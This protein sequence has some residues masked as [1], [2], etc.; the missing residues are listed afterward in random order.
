MEHSV[1]LEWNSVDS[2]LH[3]PALPRDGI[4]KICIYDFDNTLFKS[5]APNPHLYSAELYSSLLSPHVFSNGGWWSE[6]RF[7]EILV[8]EWIKGSVDDSAF[9]NKDIVDSARRSWDDRDNGTLTIL[10]TGRKELLFSPLFEKLLK[11]PVFGRELLFHSAFLKRAGYPTTMKYKIA[12]LRSVMDFYKEVNEIVIY[13][14]RKQQLEGFELFFEDYKRETSR[15]FNH[16]LIAVK[17]VINYLPPGKEIGTVAKIF[18]EHNKDVRSKLEGLEMV[19]GPICSLGFQMDNLTLDEDSNTVRYLLDCRETHKIRQL[20]TQ[21]S[22]DTNQAYP[23]SLPIIVP[24][25]SL[26]GSQV[27]MFQNHNSVTPEASTEDFRKLIGDATCFCPNKV[28]DWSIRE[29]ISLESS[30][31]AFSVGSTQQPGTHIL[32]TSDYSDE[33]MQSVMDHINNRGSLAEINHSLPSFSA[34]AIPKYHYL[35]KTACDVE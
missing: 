4:H 2:A 6:P 24:L 1:L 7:L 29:A 16:T 25:G 23:F 20:V 26:P 31:L 19:H 15:N 30:R 9:W 17:P 35:A 32:F 12:C 14:D 10:M 33:D 22:Q 27:E 34:I 11:H 3:V 28:I 13:D 8:D 5:P 18:N 21:M